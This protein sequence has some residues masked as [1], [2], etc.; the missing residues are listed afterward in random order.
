MQCGTS[1]MLFRGADLQSLLP[2]TGPA[3]DRQRHMQ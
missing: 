2:A 1:C 3:H